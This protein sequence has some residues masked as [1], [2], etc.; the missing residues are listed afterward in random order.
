MQV[1]AFAM[2]YTRYL[3]QVLQGLAVRNSAVFSGKGRDWFELQVGGVCR[4]GGFVLCC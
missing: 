4:K 1:T 3:A 2:V